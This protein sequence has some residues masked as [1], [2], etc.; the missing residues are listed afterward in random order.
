MSAIAIDAIV[1]DASVLVV[2][3]ADDGD[4][5]DAARAR[6][7]GYDLIAPEIVD[8]EVLSVLRRLVA[9]R[10]ITARRAQFAIDD[11]I[12]LPITRTPHRPLLNRC[13]E[14]KHNMTP[15]DA[16]YL[17]TAEAFHVPLLT[18]DVRLSRSPGV[19]CRIDL[20]A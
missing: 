19:R 9:S 16:A 13:W 10:K 2:A 20:L 18:A 11:L 4:N 7:G 6:L 8:L 1:I 15:Y 5:G 17:A 12:A 3:L 14:L